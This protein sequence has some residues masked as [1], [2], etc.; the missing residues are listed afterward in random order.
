MGELAQALLLDF[1]ELL[2]YETQLRHPAQKLG[3]CVFQQGP[4][5]R[6]A[7][8][9]ELVRGLAQSVLEASNAE[10]CERGFHLVVDA[11]ALAEKR[12]CKFFSVN[13][14]RAIFRSL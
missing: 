14:E 6:R 1:L 2:A 3:E 12:L 9:D 4:S 7:Q 5:L 8:L 11:R 13:S 10:A